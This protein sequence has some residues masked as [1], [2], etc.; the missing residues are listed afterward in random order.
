[1]ATEIKRLKDFIEDVDER[2]GKDSGYSL[3]DI[4]GIS[5]ITKLFQNTKANLVDVSPSGYKVVEPMYFAYNPNTA[6]MGDKIPIALNQE[7]QNVLVSSIYPVFRIKD[8]NKLH[9]QYLW[10]WFKRSE[11]DRYARFK[12]HGS[13][14]EIFSWEEMC[15]VSL[16]VPDIKTQSKIVDRYFAIESRIELLDKLSEKVMRQGIMIFQKAVDAESSEYK[17]GDALT[18]LKDG[19]HNPPERVEKGVPLI[20]G[21]TLENGFISYEKMTYITEKDYLKIHNRY[22]PQEN[23]LIITKIGTVGKVAFLRKRDIPITVHCNSALLRFNP[24]I[25]SQH[26]AFWMLLSKEFQNELKSRIANSVQDFVNLT[27]ISE[28]SIHLPSAK[29]QNEFEKA[30]VNYLDL[31]SSINL[32]REKMVELQQLIL[33]DIRNLKGSEKR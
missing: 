7:K 29:A 9:P 8:T 17:L 28:I 10:L 22:Q 15:E 21:Q 3:E 18:L 19:T 13:A 30:F 14:R 23:D 25:I 26:C 2:A 11:F 6:R 20:T 16:P 1:M 4:R 24:D 32:E 27:N 33:A 31:L 12:S 5:S